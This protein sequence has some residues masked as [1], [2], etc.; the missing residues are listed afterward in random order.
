MSRDQA[1][2]GLQV[3]FGCV[4]SRVGATRENFR[5]GRP[6]WTAFLLYGDQEGRP[7]TSREVSACAARHGDEAGQTG[8]EEQ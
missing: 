1:A 3:E 7:L 2:S 8:G 4:M 6:D 5:R